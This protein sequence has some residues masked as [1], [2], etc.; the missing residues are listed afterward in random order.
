MAKRMTKSERAEA[1][2]A[3]AFKESDKALDGVIEAVRG[4]RRALFAMY[5][6]HE[7]LPATEIQRLGMLAQVISGTTAHLPQP[8]EQ[9][10]RV[11][12]EA[13]SYVDDCLDGGLDALF[14]GVSQELVSEDETDNDAEIGRAM[15]ATD[16]TQ[17]LARGFV[18]QGGDDQ[19]VGVVRLA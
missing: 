2:K 5:V 1:A 12:D 9:E 3:K 14:E 6:R 19:P 7:P 18:R 17:V 4:L 11:Y 13:T 10:G 16:Y 15:R 8:T